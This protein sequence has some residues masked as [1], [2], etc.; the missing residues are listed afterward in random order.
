MLGFKLAIDGP[1]GSGKSTISQLLSQKLNWFYLN[2]GL[3][4]RA[5][6]FILL[7]NKVNFQNLQEKKLNSCLSQMD[8]KV[9]QNIIYVNNQDVTPF[10]NT[11]TVENQVSYISGLSLVREKILSLQQ[12]M[13]QKYSYIIMDG[14]DIGTVIMPQADL[15]IFLTASISERVIRKQ[16]KCVFSSIPLSQILEYINQ[17]D[18]K[19]MER[20]NSPLV[21]APDAVLVDTTNL[22]IVQVTNI[23]LE[24]I[25]KK[26]ENNHAF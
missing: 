17:R 6:T 9:N 3:L 14:R 1:S 11:Q 24:I 2:T 7:Q 26:Q 15:K 19:D 23:I 10:L 12:G 22:S 16:K 21:K 13:I 18:K 25:Q 5:I 8:I 4:F 20:V